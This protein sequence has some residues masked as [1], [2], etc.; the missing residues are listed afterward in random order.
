MFPFIKKYIH[1]F[2]KPDRTIKKE[3][4]FYIHPSYTKGVSGSFSFLSV[5]QVLKIPRSLP[6]LPKV[7]QTSVYEFLL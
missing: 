2:L 1:F 5:I 4:M 3:R 7:S 6:D